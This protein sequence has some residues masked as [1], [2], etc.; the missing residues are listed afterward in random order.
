MRDPKKGIGL[1]AKKNLPKNLCIPYGG[2]YRPP[3]EWKNL[4]KHSNDG[5]FHRVSH[6]AE[7]ECIRDDG[8]VEWGALD[9]HPSL[10]QE[11]KVPAGAWPGA[12]CNQGA[13][14]AELNGKLLQH[15]GSCTAPAY[16][17]MENRCRPLFVQLTRPVSAGEEILV[18]YGYTADRQT[19]WGF[20]PKAKLPTV[21]SQYTF[22][23]QTKVGKYGDT[24][25]V[26]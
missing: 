11:E 18:D 3:R 10:M 22:R 25:I 21:K 6:A 8:E 7:I 12:Y 2:K 5:G 14:R 4:Y 23:P 19:R 24:Q 13:I 1:V 15:D 9:A 26:G 17:W 20:G 16:Q